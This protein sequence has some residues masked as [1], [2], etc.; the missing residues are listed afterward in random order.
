M[1]YEAWVQDY[2]QRNDNIHEH[3]ARAK[4]GEV[5]F[6]GLWSGLAHLLEEAIARVGELVA[7][8]EA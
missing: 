3:F 8:E 6:V 4:A 7:F 2:D 1:N 5:P